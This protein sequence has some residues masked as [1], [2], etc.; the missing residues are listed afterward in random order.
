MIISHGLQ[1]LPPEYPPIMG[2]R[3]WETMDQPVKTNPHVEGILV[4]KSKEEYSYF[5]NPST[6]T[7]VVVQQPYSCDSNF[8]FPIEG[9]SGAQDWVLS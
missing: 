5:K 9:Y 8:H 4:T 7:S 3:E 6:P 2:G 1:V